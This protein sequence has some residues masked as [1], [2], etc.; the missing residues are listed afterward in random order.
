MNDYQ[1]IAAALNRNLM[2]AADM[3]DFVYQRAMN[4]AAPSE[5]TT[6]TA[7]ATRALHRVLYRAWNSLCDTADIPEGRTTTEARKKERKAREAERKL[8]LVLGRSE[9]ELLPDSF[10]H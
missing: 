8:E 2:T 7:H 3:P 10:D 9:A 5:A 4:T 1:H 6:S